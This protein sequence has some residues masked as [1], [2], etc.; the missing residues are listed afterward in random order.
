MPTSR[1]EDGCTPLHLAAGSGNLE[2]VKA[3]LAHGADPSIRDSTG[4]TALHVGSVCVCCVCVCLCVCMRVC[5]CV[6]T[7]CV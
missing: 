5:A 6:C 1:N 7:E 2:I 4:T 3:C